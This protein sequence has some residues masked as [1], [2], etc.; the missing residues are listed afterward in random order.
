M[1]EIQKM[2][3]LPSVDFGPGV[4]ALPD[5]DAQVLGDDYLP[6]T[7]EQKQFEKEWGEKGPGE[8][9][10]LGWKKGVN[11]LKG[12]VGNFFAETLP[13]I[14]KMGTALAPGGVPYNPLFPNSK[15][16]YE[17]M[18]EASDNDESFDNLI[19]RVT[20][21]SEEKF[22]IAEG[23]KGKGFVFNAANMLP[24]AMGTVAA[25]V[26]TAATG[27]APA[28]AAIPAL[29]SGGN[30]LVLSSAVVGD[31]LRQY[32]KYVEETGK[33]PNELERWGVALLAG[34]A[35]YASEKMRLNMALD[36]FVPNGL[37][38]KLMGNILRKNPEVS[39]DILSKWA[40]KFPNKYQKL[41]GFIRKVN[42]QGMEEGGEELFA[43][44][45]QTLAQNIYL[46]PEH[47]HTI[48]DA[49]QN[50]LRAAAGGYAMG[51]FLGPITVSSNKAYH[52]LRRNKEGK[53]TLLETKDGDVF[54]YV[55][56]GKNG[57]MTVID[58][59]LRPKTITRE[60]IAK[61]ITLKPQEVSQFLDAYKQGQENLPQ[62]ERELV[63]KSAERQI[64]SFGEKISFEGS[65]MISSVQDK[66]GNILFLKSEGPKALG[67]KTFVALN[68]E[69]MELV[70]L[71]ETDIAERNEISLDEWMQSEM[72]AYYQTIQQSEEV[73]AQQQVQAEVEAEMQE[74]EEETPLA[75][76]EE[77][78]YMDRKWSISE[79][80]T[81][82]TL[83][84]DEITEDGVG[85]SIEIK[86]EDAANI[87]RTGQQEEEQPGEQEE[88]PEQ[89][90]P[91]YS[92]NGK[93]VTKGYVKGRIRV[94]KSLNDLNGLAWKNDK[95]LDKMV[96]ERFPEAV[97]EYKV[98]KDKADRDEIIGIIEGA[99]DIS[100]LEGVT[101]KNDDE[102]TEMLVAKATELN[103]EVIEEINKAEPLKEEEEIKA[104]PEQKAEET[105]KET[106]GV[107]ETT[108]VVGETD[109]AW[110]H[111][112]NN[113]V[114]EKGKSR[115]ERSEFQRVAQEMLRSGMPVNEVIGKINKKYSLNI[116]LFF[117]VEGAAKDIKEKP[118]E[119]PPT[120]GAGAMVVKPQP[121][122]AEGEVDQKEPTEREKYG[123]EQLRPT[124]RGTTLSE[125]EAIQDGGVISSDNMQEATWITDKK[126]YADDYAK[127]K[128][129]GVIIEFKPEVIDK[130]AVESG[131]END[132]TGI[133]LGKGLTI[134]DILRVTNAKGEVIYEAGKE[135]TPVEKEEKTEQ[136]EEQAPSKQAEVEKESAKV[137]T[138]PS[139]AQKK[140]GNYKKGHVSIQ[141]MEIS[142]EQPAL[143]I[144]SGKDS[145]GNKWSV[146]LH[147]PYGYFRRTEGKDG[148]Q[149]DV[150]L[151]DNLESKKV[152]VIDQ[153]VPGTGEFDEHKVM[154]GFEN[155]KEAEDNYLANYEPGWKGLGEIVEM[156]IDEFK[157]WL[158]NGTR[159]K[160]PVGELLKEQ[161]DK[162]EEVK[163][164]AYNEF[165]EKYKSIENIETLNTAI[166][167]L[168]ALQRK[169]G[170]LKHGDP[171]YPWGTIGKGWGFSDEL[172]NK[173]PGEQNWEREE[174]GLTPD[175][176]GWA[177][178]NRIDLAKSPN[179]Y[180]ASEYSW[181]LGSS[182]GGSAPSIH[183][184]AFATRKE[185]LRHGLERFI[186]NMSK[187]KEGAETKSDIAYA[188]KLLKEAKAK[189]NEIGGPLKKAEFAGDILE[190]PKTQKEQVKQVLKGEESKSIKEIADETGIVEPSIRR[191]LGVGT[192][193]G[194]FERVD[195]GVYKLVTEDGKT[196]AWI[197]AGDAVEVLPRLAKEGFKADMIFLD[198]PYTTSAIKSG[199][200]ELNFDKISPQ[201]F[202]KVV[203][204]ISQIAR[205]EDTPVL[206]MH[207][208]SKTG[209]KDMEEYLQ[210]IEKEFKPVAK[211]FYTKYY[212][213][214]NRVT[215][216]M[217]KDFLPPEAIV[218]M[219]KSGEFTPISKEF[220]LDFDLV[221]PKGYPTEK[222]A[223][224]LRKLIEMTTYEKDMILDPFAGS[225]V[226][227]AEAVKAGR[228]VTLIEKSEKAVEGVIKPRVER[229]AKESEPTVSTEG[230]TSP[231]IEI[232]KDEWAVMDVTKTLKSPYRRQYLK[233]LGIDEERYK[234]IKD[235]LYRKKIL[236]ANGGI[237]GLGLAVVDGLYKRAGVKS[238]V[239]RSYEKPDSPVWNLWKK[240]EPVSQE[241]GLRESWRETLIKAREAAV[242]V[243]TKEELDELRE[244]GLDWTDREAI[245][246]AVDN[247]L[248]EKP[249]EEGLAPEVGP[250]EERMNDPGT[251]LA[252][253]LKPG[254]VFRNIYIGP[255]YKWKREDYGIYSS[256]G[257]PVQGME[258][259]TVKRVEDKQGRPGYH[260]YWVTAIRTDA[261]RKKDGGFKQNVLDAE[262]SIYNFVLHRGR[263]EETHA[264]VP[265][266]TGENME[267]IFVIDDRASGVKPKPA[268]QQQ[269]IKPVEKK[270]PARKK[271]PSRTD[272][273]LERDPESFLE[274]TLQFF[275]KGG[276]IA[277]QDFV[278]HT[279]FKPKTTEFRKFIWAIKNTG[280]SLDVFNEALQNSFGMEDKGP[281]DMINEVIE[282]MKMY[283][284]RGKMLNALEDIQNQQEPQ[285]REDIPDMEVIEA[286]LEDMDRDEDFDYILNSET[287]GP[288]IDEFTNW[289]GYFN[290]GNLLAKI[291]ADPFYFTTF[292]YG[293][294]EQEL[295]DFKKTL[296]NDGKSI[297]ERIKAAYRAFGDSE[298]EN[299]PGSSEGDEIRTGAEG[300]RG[301]EEEID[302]A[303]LFND[304][305][306]KEE[307]VEH[308]PID[309]ERHSQAG[310]SEVQADEQD[311]PEKPV[312]SSEGRRKTSESTGKGTGTELSTT[313]TR[314]DSPGDM[315][316]I[317][318]VSG[319]RG[320]R[321]VHKED[322]RPKSDEGFAGDLF[323]AGGVDLHGE[324]QARP[325]RE[326]QEGDRGDVEKTR[327]VSSYKVKAQLEAESIPVKEN[328]VQNIK[329]TLPFLFPEQH[330]DVIKTER[331][332]QEGKGMLFSNATGTGKTY[333]GLG[334]AKRFD[335][336]GK[337]NILIVVPTDIKAKDWIRDGRNL[338]LDIRQL[339]NTQDGGDKI[340]VTTY[341]NFKQN[342]ELLKREFD[343]II[344]DESH[345]IMANQKGQNTAGTEAHF[346]ISNRNYGWALERLKANTGLWKREAEIQ[347][348]ISEWNAENNSNL[349]KG[350]NQVSWEYSNEIE[351]LERELEEVKAKQDEVLPDLQEKA[352]TAS[353][354]TKVVFLSATPFKSHFT[355]RYANDYLYKMGSDSR[356]ES[357]YNEGSS[358]D[359]FFISNFGYRMRYNK[360]TAP[361]AEVDV[362][363]LERMFVDNMI[364]KGSFA[365][366]ML[367]TDYDYSR[368]FPIISN[369]GSVS[370]NEGIRL[371]L[372]I[373]KNTH[374]EFEALD[375]YIHFRFYNYLY[376]N[377][378]F[379]VLKAGM[380]IPRIKQ[381]LE[382]GRKVVI[383]H[384]Y[385]QAKVD[386]PFD[387]SNAYYEYNDWYNKI[388]V[389]KYLRDDKKAIEAWEKF[390]AKYSEYLGLKLDLRNPI[391]QLQDAFPGLLVFNGDVPK[392]VRKERQAL[393]NDP[394][395]GSNI[396]LIQEQA[397]REGIDLHDIT[398][399]KQRVLINLG[400]PVDPITALQA[401]GR[402]NRIGLMSNAVF[403][404]PVLGLDIEKY[405]FGSKINERIGTTENLSLGNKARDLRRSFKDG[406]LNADVFSPN[407]QQGTGGKKFDMPETLERD[408]PYQKARALYYT[409]KKKTSRE[410]SA[411]GIDY[412]ATPEP[413]GFKMWQWLQ[414][415]R[416]ERGLEPSAGHGAISRFAP[417][418]VEL[419][420]IEPSNV[421]FSKLMVNAEGKK[422]NQ[423]F[424]DFY[425]GNKFE[426]VAM[427][428]PFGT[429]G[430][431][432][433][434]HL[435]K[436]FGHLSW[437]GG[438]V[439]AI[440]P[441]GPSM[442]KRLDKFLH[443]EDENGKQLHPDAFLRAEINLPSVSFERAGTSVNAKIV[444]IDKVYKADQYDIPGPVN[445]DLSSHTNINE[446]F[447][448]LENV[449]VPAK[450]SKEDRKVE[451]VKKPERWNIHHIVR[452]KDNEG[453]IRVGTIRNIVEVAGV[454]RH[455]FIVQSAE[456]MPESFDIKNIIGF[457]SEKDLAMKELDDVFTGKASTVTPRQEKL[458]TTS[459]ELE[460]I[461]QQHTKEG[462]DLH[463]I[464]LNIRL[465]KDDFYSLKRMAKNEGGYYSSYKGQGA[466]PGF[467]FKDEQ[468]AKNFLAKATDFLNN[469]NF[470]VNERPQTYRQAEK[471]PVILA[472]SAF[473]QELPLDSGSA[474]VQREEDTGQDRSGRN[475]PSLRK[476]GPGE[477]ARLEVKYTIDKNLVFNGKEKIESQD[478]V[479]FLFR[480]LEDKAVENIFA[481]HVLEN[482]KSVIQ[483]IS[484]GSNAGSIV[485]F[486]A[487]ADGINRFN[488]VKTYFIHNHP[489]GNINPSRADITILSKLKDAFGDVIN[490][491]GIIIDIDSGLYGTFG[492]IEGFENS[493]E[494]PKQAPEKEYKVYRFDR[495]VFNKDIDYL[496][497]KHAKIKEQDEAAQYASAQRHTSGNKLSALILSRQNKI[498]A[499]IHYPYSNL[500]EN[501]H[502][503]M[504]DTR[505][506]CARFNASGLILYGRGISEVDVIALNRIKEELKTTD[507]NLLD[508]FDM[509]R[510]EAG[511]GGGASIMMEPQTDYTNGLQAEIERTR[512]ELRKVTKARQDK[513]NELSKRINTQGALFAGEV[514]GPTLEQKTTFDVDMDATQENIK[515]IL[516]DYDNQIARLQKRL[517]DLE[518]QAERAAIENKGQ[519]VLFRL[520]DEQVFYSNT[521]KALD[522]IK[523]DKAPWTQ[524]QAMLVKNGAKQSEMDWLDLEGKF[525][526]RK[527]VTREE[528]Q[529]HID[530]SKIDIKEIDMSKTTDPDD[531]MDYNRAYN[532]LQETINKHDSERYELRLSLAK[533]GV[534]VEDAEGWIRQLD[535]Q[536]FNNFN[537]NK[538]ADAVN[539]ILKYLPDYDINAYHDVVDAHKRA[540]DRF[541]AAKSRYVERDYTKYSRWTLP[542][543][544]NY[545]EIL[546]TLKKPVK[547][548]DPAEE[549][550]RADRWEEE[551]ADA[552]FDIQERGATLE[553][554]FLS[555]HWDEPNVIS[556]VRL[557]E[558]T[559]TQG[560]NILFIE[561][562]QSDWAQK[563]R[564]EGG[565]VNTPER[566][567]ETLQPYLDDLIKRDKALND[568]KKQLDD[569]LA[570]MR[571]Y[572]LPQ[573][574]SS[575]EIEW[576]EL[577]DYNFLAARNE[578]FRRLMERQKEVRSNKEYLEIDDEIE[579]IRERAILLGRSRKELIKR[580][581]AAEE[582][583]QNAR[584]TYYD[585]KASLTENMVPD[586]PFKKTSEWAGLAMRR[587]IRYAI[588]N[589]FDAIAWTTGQQQ[590]ERYELSKQ[591]QKIK[592]RKLD[593]GNYAVDIT[594]NEGEE[595]V[596]FGGELT[597]NRLEEYIGKELAKKIVEDTGK[598]ND[599]KRIEYTGTDL[600]V[601]GEGMKS[602]YDSILPSVA[603]KIGKKY[604]ARVQSLE[605]RSSNKGVTY[606]TYN[607]D[608]TPMKF[609]SHS[610]EEAKEEIKKN[611]GY[612][613][614]ITFDYTI[615][616]DDAGKYIVI[617]EGIDL[618]DSYD[619]EAVVDFVQG[620]T[621]VHTMPITPE[622]FNAFKQGVP[623]YRSIET[624]KGK[625][626]E[627]QLEKPTMA[628]KAKKEVLGRIE[629][630]SKKYG[631]DINA[632]DTIEDLPKEI[633]DQVIRS[634]KSKRVQGLYDPASDS[635]YVILNNNHSF[636]EILK[637]IMHEVVGH[638]GVR[639]LLGEE[640]TEVM[641][642]VYNGMDIEDI[643]AL[644]RKYNTTD[645][646]T[647]ADEYLAL[648]AERN[649]NPTLL[650]KAIA[651]IRQA[652]RKLFKL[653]YSYNDVINLLADTRKML[654]ESQKPK[655]SDYTNAQDY[656]DAVE[657]WH[658]SP[659]A[660]IQNFTTGR[661][662]T[663]EGYQSYGWGMYFTDKREVAK[664]YAEALAKYDE[665]Y[666]K[667]ETFIGQKSAK[668]I[669]K[670]V[671]YSGY[672]HNKVIP[673]LQEKIEKYKDNPNIT[674]RF[675]KAIKFIQDNPLPQNRHL[676]K[677]L[678]RKGRKPG[679]LNFINFLEPLKNKDVVLISDQLAR[680]GITDASLEHALW[681]I[682]PARVLYKQ[683]SRILGSDKEAS[684]LLSRAGI[685]G[686]IYPTEISDREKGRG[687]GVNYV[688]FREDNITVKDRLSYRLSD[689][690]PEKKGP[691]KN[692]I[693]TAAEKRQATWQDRMLSVK[694][695]QNSIRGRGGMITESSNPYRQ[696]NL[697]HG[698]V[699]HA[700]E[701]YNEKYVDPL[702]ETIGNMMNTAGIDYEEVNLYMKAK[703]AP[704]RNAELRERTGKD[705][706]AGMTDEAA[707]EI[708]DRF[709]SKFT[710]ET[711][712]TLW[713]KIN[714]A[715][716][717]TLK[718]W[719]QD[720]F[721]S[722]DLYKKIAGM[723]DYYVP[724][725][726]WKK[727]ELDE[728]YE[729]QG[730]DVGKVVNPL[731]TA[732]GRKS[733][734]DDPLQY[735]VNMA[736]TAVVTG[737]KNRIKQH[738]ARLVRNNK[739]MTDLHKFKK[740]YRVF[741]GSYDEMG[742]KNYYET[743]ER[744]AQ[745]I[746]DRGWVLTKEDTQHMK[747]RAMSQAKEHETE[748]WINGDKYV[749]VLPADVSNALNKTPSRWDNVAYITRNNFGRLTRWLSSNFTSKNPAFI[750]INQM[751]DLQYAALA[752]YCKGDAKQSL[753]FMKAL[754]KA[755]GAII[756][757]LK[758]KGEADNKY[759]QMYLDFMLNGGETGWVHL[760]DVDQLAKEMEKELARMTGKNT[761][762]D[763]TIHNKYLR[764]AG[765]WM[766]HMAIRSE[767]LSRF[768]TYIIAIEA[769]KSPKQAAFEAK[770]ITVNFNRKGRASSLMGSLYAFF[771]ASLQGGNNIYNL[772]KKH[773]AKF[774]GVGAG[775]M[776]MGF[777]SAM[778]NHLWGGDD[779]EGDNYYEGLNDYVKYNH[780]VIKSPFGDRFLTI[781][782]PHGF[783]WFNSL[784]V[785][786]YENLFT[787]SKTIGDSVKD[788]VSNAFASI[789][790]VNPVEFLGEDEQLTLRPLVPTGLMPWYDI[791][792]NADFTGRNIHREPFTKALDGRIA[793][794]SLGQ[795][796]VN[797][798]V[799]WLTDNLFKVGGGDPDVGSKFYLDD[800]GKIHKVSDMFDKNPSDI[801]HMIEYY[802]GGRGTFWNNLVKTS[803][804]IVQGAGEVMTGD[805][806]FQ[807]IV[808]DV[809][810][811]NLPI[812]RRLL[813]Q[814]WNNT[815]YSKYYKIVDEIEDYKS[816]ISQRNK[817]LE[818]YEKEGFTPE[819]QI[820]I[821]MLNMLKDDLEYID[822]DIK[823][824][825]DPRQVKEF[826]GLQEM[827]IRNFIEDISKYE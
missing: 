143:S 239:G 664:G 78:N 115:K 104:E 372:S 192:K 63:N 236:L 658:G 652:I 549:Q 673:F 257:Y 645:K 646:D 797:P 26:A 789:S 466:I 222:P 581:E 305:A 707:N 76:G 573:G 297:Q 223:E 740:I 452:F 242:S 627:E 157:E 64:R 747:G 685:D 424:E 663:G 43:E 588:D 695:W 743:T 811:N 482:G 369:K 162:Q 27:G 167:E 318:P 271:K 470:E 746:W 427:N 600:E 103:P 202:D 270:K 21:A 624:P 654:R 753:E 105:T 5:L 324:R 193:Q 110:R 444:V 393:F 586:M 69:T 778:L 428:P 655:A 758:G 754:P 345:H 783:R 498:V 286:D 443:G 504:A 798:G 170:Y 289:E 262:E 189:L 656:L 367:Q 35:E 39:S 45:I 561:E 241:Q 327:K 749:M 622:L 792:V 514:F 378:L 580:R 488:P 407:E 244:K 33:D 593:N 425:V 804:S 188:E 665:Y 528:L 414:L 729:Y 714:A 1:K 299:T 291:E 480:K 812:V 559:D 343:L 46:D 481:L 382:M 823:L 166:E 752:H 38:G 377:Q 334:V 303:E 463:T 575:G 704:E 724:L 563:I 200:R 331:R 533:S 669:E 136:E 509:K 716:G 266:T 690:S 346:K 169:V 230:I 357:G 583:L 502:D 429:G 440:I 96:A 661:V 688:V 4:E 602:F 174:V 722:T 572:G 184:K 757:Y 280:Q 505:A 694:K 508:A 253:I 648:M 91:D 328:D 660:G 325:R 419:T 614:P 644:E 40:K 172:A 137:D 630:L 413:L 269:E 610:L 469:R 408:D 221:R 678:I 49:V 683:L 821:D 207:S 805:K 384:R 279:G 375:K 564:R 668:W 447:D 218:L 535:E 693:K 613:V 234:E 639:R 825:E 785:I 195:K 186:E 138:S 386:H 815:V 484:V 506:Y 168:F 822:E 771:N 125:W 596:G 510:I 250:G 277:T 276:R 36:K 16:M 794:S 516:S 2:F 436:A 374:P 768:A 682:T 546:L 365:G 373:N 411:E 633:R 48:G 240:E 766:E 356:M 814:P 731:K 338:N 8:K 562:I 453:K 618:F 150:F 177:V 41:I 204:S 12:G 697:S 283:P 108:T 410:K 437:K 316:D 398:G 718:R 461:K 134:D 113:I 577:G 111:I 397:G 205:S 418:G 477:F 777:L 649:V 779:D 594:T 285:D 479:A 175:K 426:G 229:A 75:P 565:V 261:P 810:M 605:L 109:P 355:L 139:E 667:A 473:D 705:V 671:F 141:G 368:D 83:Y 721:I 730:E 153:V 637:S 691:P 556:H 359:Q 389:R 404:Y 80:G 215:M 79:I 34:A 679:E 65:D 756:R 725:R 58:N 232:T 666:D 296:K 354:R 680:E 571:E 183:S 302:E 598:T 686:F 449:E 178:M 530:R 312:D 208:T 464:K 793:D 165:S 445:I 566:L 37:T 759:D 531:E 313:G 379:E 55:G 621:K 435:E 149:V 748:V 74:K 44:F 543:G 551:Y 120:G 155:F 560:R 726:N 769:G 61:S 301:E 380:M 492:S 160:K 700:V 795:S 319:E 237:T 17:G 135:A 489:S 259:L 623:L 381:H 503:F 68:A 364:K 315:G 298:E 248:N 772:G 595:Y 742:N 117:D 308:R 233:N 552:P 119:K 782:L 465:D 456:E 550:A 762:W 458:M 770:E 591:V 304:I 548:I 788:A 278:A 217:R 708:I 641:N 293:L 406:F 54:E 268:T 807:N 494:I 329:D 585:R 128:D 448:A 612:I 801:E 638:K 650:Q 827:L 22:E 744:P 307:D 252:K 493:Y 92:F 541:L 106:S 507:I 439:V 544:K 574:A 123:L 438:R 295:K 738:A 300:E 220:D 518:K 460:L 803:A 310:T 7:D 527:S 780:L 737:E 434:E 558:R 292:P 212:R 471:E 112:R 416:G 689:E 203:Q 142:I 701:Q 599:G 818:R 351:P 72:E 401:E 774:L 370:L 348:R 360:L 243:F 391:Q 592:A 287:Y 402:I 395:S 82:G 773:T 322:E 784:G 446:F 86:P 3:A 640:W 501:R 163:R 555:G 713:N 201:Q 587:M 211:G 60:D 94:A 519:G 728:F 826:K 675:E 191:I 216:P 781:P 597:E 441:A 306:K 676:Y 238:I 332:F 93:E 25:A 796:Y 720:G 326:G 485:N 405:H 455:F 800:N 158:G 524:W 739:D 765:Q 151:G 181:S 272:K 491:L 415:N 66:E 32:D 616:R 568:I 617:R 409:N 209:T 396:I 634:G 538:M 412:F 18:V 677:V 628:G 194:E 787:D 802:L 545:K 227:G 607:P 333:T 376:S 786:A 709:E 335:K 159:T 225:G 736:H 363:A 385:K 231:A 454:Q 536:N 476:L 247:K 760:K 147:N 392:K 615:E 224:M 670:A 710:E 579:R 706:N 311:V 687:K 70:I 399:N 539:N 352:K 180:W 273:V 140:A 711:I 611:N 474:E 251:D 824:I 813:R 421:L 601:G 124:Y 127:S 540:E 496:H 790:P 467:N 95:D 723:Y 422:V 819:W 56:T 294:S 28:L 260:H 642:L 20:Q 85:E 121:E 459:R 71:K 751:R 176:K 692:L 733:E 349:D 631:I 570:E 84:V 626:L 53:V 164:Q 309:T 336:Q 468:A 608:G 173:T 254:M 430:K 47:K 199:N 89:E 366:R 98:G 288:I 131:Q 130:S 745:D 767:N 515:R 152:F 107:D 497:E 13:Q 148:D 808:D 118:P 699:K 42:I 161:E 87:Q 323:T 553:G 156:D 603:N 99:T 182:G 73:A 657:A 606:F 809:N 537:T 609:A 604:G 187:R 246:K 681:D 761:V 81:D 263:I 619:I 703:H 684:L 734:A 196:T 567:K 154:L 500:N 190:K 145:K 523:Q 52:Y 578:R 526:D 132:E 702:L 342:P 629:L 362:S 554:D 487:I 388:R 198:I 662:G 11:W 90:L 14:S 146:M 6:Q 358:E 403:E 197:H 213:N 101:V 274:A 417:D 144:R 763:K 347:R 625:T 320:D 258:V 249:T 513:K 816:L 62:L 282:I 776:A 712:N 486:N 735:I 228:D 321:Q 727:T 451:E 512:E 129:D 126:E 350:E 542:G 651:R 529:Q 339:D 77:I 256:E 116:P 275:V 267:R 214:G 636:D 520:A 584:T 590:A 284:S 341:A 431:I 635:I 235:S 57:Q 171:D 643:Q 133:R 620:V 317:A 88:I 210:V 478:D 226:T 19:D 647:I 102:L 442:D 490:P 383:F 432:A 281:M 817:G 557:N 495:M 806:D 100:D 51:G 337:S 371:L 122:K 799:K 698:A 387:F 534:S 314:K 632:V 462:Y 532:Y 50:S 420:S 525:K 791:W 24:Q 23:I 344:Y 741:D 820:K 185:A 264:P 340:N 715:T 353:E 732:R 97:P 582:G 67:K 499:N 219:T 653:N 475:R 15:E 517:A 457:A 400:M 330:D 31:Q 9:F 472:E 423:R 10:G 290:V 755:R 59:D 245:V 569:V 589:G 361:E 390:Q 450:I 674:L 521:Q 576:F 522:V 255:S 29:V 30:L 775:F 672:D 717:Y 764:I 750:P 696:E 511:E 719:M 179:G 114:S 265:G 659:Y 547:A 206:F 394:N 483:H 433:M